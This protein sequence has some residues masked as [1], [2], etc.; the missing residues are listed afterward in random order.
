MVAMLPALDPGPIAAALDLGAKAAG[1]H[2][3]DAGEIAAP[4][5]A[6]R[7]PRFSLEDLPLQD[8]ELGADGLDD[9]VA[10]SSQHAVFGP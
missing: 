3:Q 5:D 4:H 6:C 2:S 7:G 1:G 10:L 8:L 9:P